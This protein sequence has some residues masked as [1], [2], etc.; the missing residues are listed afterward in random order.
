MLTERIPYRLRQI[1]RLGI[2][3]PLLVPSFSSRGFPD[4][5]S[6]IEA[7][8]VDI[9]GACLL[10]AFDIAQGH[11]PEAFEELADMI[12]VDS[13]LYETSPIAD[14]VDCF[15]P[16]PIRAAWTRDHYHSFLKSAAVRVANTNALVVSFDSYA[17]LEKQIED[18][19]ADFAL[20][21]SAARDFLLKP[22]LLGQVYVC[23]EVVGANLNGFE[24]IGVTEREL[25]RSAI[26]RCRALLDLRA[27]IDAAGGTIPIHVFG[28]I[29]PAAVTAYFLCGADIF[30]GLNWLRV[31][32]DAAWAGAP[33]EFAVT[34]R[35]FEAGDEAVLLELWRRNLRTLK[36]TQIALRRFAT[37]GDRQA[38]C[39]VLPFAISSL[40]LA[41][42][43]KAQSHRPGRK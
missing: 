15:Q 39:H 23:S 28:S 18:A 19:H 2:G 12:L 36:R 7:L 26:D 32:L 31:C 1:D 13:G 17:P 38:L 33:S 37:D 27:V 11:V 8:R 34:G 3:T 21:P 25:G 5:A 29:T 43:A 4:V 41:D 20:A 24:V 6:I 9:S 30:D 16:D 10:S 40:A 22:G 14:A 35:L 42:T